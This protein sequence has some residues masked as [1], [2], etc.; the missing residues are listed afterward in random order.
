MSIYISFLLS[1]KHTIC[2]WS[3]PIDCPILRE[4][5]NQIF[6]PIQWKRFLF[7]DSVC[8]LQPRLVIPS[9]NLFFFVFI[10]WYSAL[11]IHVPPIKVILAMIFR[12]LFSTLYLS[13]S[14][15]TLVFYVFILCGF[16]LFRLYFGYDLFIILVGYDL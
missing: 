15:W 16:E 9:P 3:E 4:E 10:I 6:L 12:L 1:R 13:F 8:A 11:L 7:K 2:T 14:I 5:R